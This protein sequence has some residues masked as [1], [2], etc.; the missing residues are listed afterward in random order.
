M[1]H[2]TLIGV[3]ND[4]PAHASYTAIELYTICAYIASDIKIIQITFNKC[5]LVTPHMTSD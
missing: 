5:S 2:T 3:C 1:K 4:L